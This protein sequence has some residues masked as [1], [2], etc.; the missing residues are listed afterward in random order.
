MKGWLLSVAGAAMLSSLA[1]ALCPHGRVRQATRFVCALVC[2]LSLL[3]PLLRLDEE[4]TL[5]PALD[6]YR[7]EAEALTAAG[8]EAAK[9]E[10]RLLIEREC[11]AYILDEAEALGLTVGGASVLAR[12]NADEGVWQPA[13]ATVEAAYNAA[14]SA[15]IETRLG[16]PKEAQRWRA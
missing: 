3:K 9:N 5:L 10:Q 2:M 6:D 14:L 1:L 7:A 8:E 13:Y 4:R 11:A 16:I 15:A 12:W